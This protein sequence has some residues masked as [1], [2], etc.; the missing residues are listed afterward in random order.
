[1]KLILDIGNTRTKM[2]VFNHEEIVAMEVVP[3]LDEVWV[4]KVVEQYGIS[5]VMISAVGH[6]PG[7]ENI[8][9]ALP[10]KI[11]STQ[12]RLPVEVDYLTPETLGADRLAAVAGAREICAEGSCLVMDAGTCITVDYLDS[13]NVYRGGAI[14]P[15]LRMKFEALHNF[16]E[17]L[18]L[19]EIESEPYDKDTLEGKSTRQSISKGVLNATVFEL[20]GFVEHFCSRDPGLKVVITGGDADFLAPL[21]KEEPI[22]ERNLLFIGLNKILETNEE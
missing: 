10:V 14:L 11:L 17:K 5:K 1:M 2:A 4:R 21:L 20:N 19:L 16:T 6:C 13:Q 7:V 3:V 8:F 18:P 15:G 22:V 12:M 9:G